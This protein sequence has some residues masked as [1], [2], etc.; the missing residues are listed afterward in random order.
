M[1]PMAVT[2][3]DTKDLKRLNESKLRLA[4][5]QCR[6]TLAL[7]EFH[8]GGRKDNQTKAADELMM[9]LVAE[10]QRRKTSPLQGLHNEPDSTPV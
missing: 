1:A 10:L 9:R 7:L 5:S 8:A 3:F 2:S 4:V 6:E